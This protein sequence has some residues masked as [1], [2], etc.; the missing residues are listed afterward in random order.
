MPLA[1]CSNH[2]SHT[3]ILIIVTRDIL[4]TKI[5]FYQTRFFFNLHIFSLFS[6]KFGPKT[7]SF[8]P[9][10]HF[11]LAYYEIVFSMPE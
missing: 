11:F 7:V 5:L 1:S 3:T 9:L 4:I 6:K 8:F 2:L 10:K